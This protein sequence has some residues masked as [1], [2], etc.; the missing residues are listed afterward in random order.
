V[1]HDSK[2]SD[3]QLS[4]Q[5]GDDMAHA[6][7]KGVRWWCWAVG[8][9]CDGGAGAVSGNMRCEYEDERTVERSK[10]MTNVAMKR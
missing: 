3:E 5:R 1:Q 7:T 8:G 6:P 2:G 9:G 4:M 10:E